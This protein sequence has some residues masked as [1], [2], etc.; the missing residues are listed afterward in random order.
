MNNKA[1]SLTTR[2]YHGQGGDKNSDHQMGK[3]PKRG[4]DIIAATIYKA[5][6]I[7]QAAKEHELLT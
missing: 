1:N 6:P 4:A 2:S 5:S 3:M 7:S